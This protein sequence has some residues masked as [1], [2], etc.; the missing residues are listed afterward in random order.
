MIEYKWLMEYQELEEE[1][2][3]MKWN[4]NKTRLELIRLEK[5]DLAKVRITNE[6]KGAYIEEAIKKI[7]NG[8]KLREEIKESL[9]LLIDTF[10]GYKNQM[11][12]KKYI[13]GK[14]LKVIAEE[15]DYH[16]VYIR[17][18]H[19]EIVADHPF[20]KESHKRIKKLKRDTA[21]IDNEIW[22]LEQ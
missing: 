19:A 21:D 20:I 6:S 22:E 5:G 3:N 12:K 14:T 9:M 15:L 11:L 2:A 8:L 16:A 18:R 13:E 4:L 7:E 10:K 1:I 17:R